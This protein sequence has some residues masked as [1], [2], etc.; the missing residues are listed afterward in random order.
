M[1]GFFYVARMDEV[2]TH[3][4]PG[5]PHIPRR[6]RPPAPGAPGRTAQDRQQHRPCQMQGRPCKARH[7]RPDVDTLHRSAP[8]TRQDARG[9]SD[10][11]RGAGLPAH[12]V[13]NCADLDTAQQRIKINTKKCSMLRVQLDTN[14]KKCY[15]NARNKRTLKSVTPPQNRRT[16]P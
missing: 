15:Y 5:A 4:T 11:S 14:T 16:K 2:F 9:R 3:P 10:R 8:D 6:W 12:C 7:A 1:W 13:R